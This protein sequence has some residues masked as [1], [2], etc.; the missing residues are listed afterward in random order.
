MNMDTLGLLEDRYG[1]LRSAVRCHKRLKTRAQGNSSGSQKKV[2]S[3][4]GQK[5]RSAVLALRKEHFN[6]PSRERV[7]RGTSKRTL[8]DEKKTNLQKIE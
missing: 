1:D 7:A 2:A 6:G 5:I 3:A 8:S 4:R